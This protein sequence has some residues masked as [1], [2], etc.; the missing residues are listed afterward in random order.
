M[1]NVQPMGVLKCVIACTAVC[2]SGC[3]NCLWDGPIFIA[4]TATTGTSL[5]SGA[6]AGASS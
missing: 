1:N 2:G 3:L 4:D 6:G 5:A